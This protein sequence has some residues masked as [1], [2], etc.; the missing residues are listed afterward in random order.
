MKAR[1]ATVLAIV[2]LISLN[3]IPSNAAVKSGLACTK[4]GSTAIAAGY[5]YTCIKLGKKIVWKKGVK[6]PAPKPAP[7]V[8][9]PSSSGVTPTPTSAQTG[10]K[11]I[12]RSEVASHNKESDCWTYVDSK[13]YDLTSWLPQHP[14]GAAIMLS[15]C[16]GDGA[17]AFRDHHKTEQDNAL[18]TY[19]IGDLR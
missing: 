19:Y 2:L 16:G 10:V 14:G 17:A 12:S 7:N 11:T 4:V 9:T 13:V 1:L 18:V 6:L 3:L 5:K 15:M 8:A